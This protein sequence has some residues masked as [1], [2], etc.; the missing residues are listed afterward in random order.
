MHKSCELCPRYEWPG[1]V[2]RL[3]FEFF[4]CSLQF[5]LGQSSNNESNNRDTI[6][7]ICLRGLRS[8][9]SISRTSLWAPPTPCKSQARPTAKPSMSCISVFFV[10]TFYL[11]KTYKSVDFCNG[12][13]CHPIYYIPAGV[14]KN[15]AVPPG[16]LRF[17]KFHF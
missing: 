8:T 7:T 9:W 13:S 11:Q 17:L 1:G 4:V 10:H 12:V 3:H 16:L 14:F 2:N 5:F 15:T 6:T